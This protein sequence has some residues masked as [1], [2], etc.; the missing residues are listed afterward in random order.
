MPALTI[1]SVRRIRRGHKVIADKLSHRHTM[2]TTHKL[3]EI[4]HRIQPLTKRRNHHTLHNPTSISRINTLSKRM[5]IPEA[6]A[7]NVSITLR[8][9][10]KN[11]DVA[12]VIPPAISATDAIIP[13]RRVEV[14]RTSGLSGV[15]VVGH[16]NSPFLWLIPTV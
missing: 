16:F 13:A 8:P 2:H 3:R 1:I 5:T 11:L 4:I 10:V 14:D 7:L 9:S 6:I 12:Q 15:D